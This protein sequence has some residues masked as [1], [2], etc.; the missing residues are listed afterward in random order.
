MQN[1]RWLPGHLVEYPTL[2][3][4]AWADILKMTIR[5]KIPKKTCKPRGKPK[6]VHGSPQLP[7]VDPLKAPPLHAPRRGSHVPVVEEATSHFPHSSHEKNLPIAPS[8]HSHSPRCCVD[9]KGNGGDQTQHQ[10]D[11]HNLSPSRT[12]SFSMNRRFKLIRG[13]SEFHT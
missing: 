6:R 10:H 13:R 4:L 2:G 12:L 1:I 5:G 9:S 7:G 8:T 3:N 11:I